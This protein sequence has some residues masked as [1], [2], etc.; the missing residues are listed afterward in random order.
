MPRNPGTTSNQGH[1]RLDFS[2]AVAPTDALVFTDLNDFRIGT[3]CSITGTSKDGGWQ[4]LGGSRPFYAWY[5]YIRDVERCRGTH[6]KGCW[7]QLSVR[8]DADFVLVDPGVG[9]ATPT[10]EFQRVWTDDRWSVWPRRRLV[11][12]RIQQVDVVDQLRVERR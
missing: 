3:F 8:Y 12:R 1:R 7:F 4:Y 6:G 2:P 11:G 5:V 10:A 9:D